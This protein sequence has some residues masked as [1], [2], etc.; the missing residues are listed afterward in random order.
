VYCVNKV[1][2]ESK[3]RYPSIQKL[4]YA[5]LITFRK[6]CHFFDEYQI[7]VVT[8]FLL[9]DILHNQDATERISKLGSGTGGSQHRFQST[10]NHQVTSTS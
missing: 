10:Y 2:S 3:V 8:D 6:L 1:L 5:I 7:L 4:L 9:A